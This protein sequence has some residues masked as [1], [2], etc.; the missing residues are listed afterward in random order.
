MQLYLRLLQYVKPYTKLMILSFI[1]MAVVGA[2]TAA[3]PLMIK[4]IVDNA[5]LGKQ[6]SLLLPYAL[7]LLGIG[8]VKESFRF[9]QSY[10]MRYVGE[11]V[12]MNIRNQLYAHIHTL[13]LSFFKGARTGMLMSRITNDVG[14][15]QNAVSDAVKDLFRESLTMVGLIAVAFYYDWWFALQ[16]IAIFPFFAIPF[17]IIGRKLRKISKRSQEKIADISSILQETFSGARIVKAFVRE[18]EESERFVKQNRKFFDITMKGVKYDEMSSPVMEFLGMVGGCFIILFAGY[19]ILNGMTTL[20]NV[21]TFGASVFMMY[22]PVKRLSRVYNS[23]QQGLAAAERVFE[24][25][26]TRA[27]VTDAPQAQDLPAFTDTINFEQASFSYDSAQDGLVLKDI[28]LK[29]KKGENLALVG[30]SGVGKS[31]LVD[32]IPRFYDVTQG[33]I[34][35]D[36]QDLRQIKV[37]SL[38]SHIAMVTQEIILFNDTVRGNIL[39]GRLD[40]TEEEVTAAARAAY[41][42]DF[43]MQM[44]EGYDTVIGERGVRL[45]GGERQR[46]AI[47]R[48]ILKKASIIILDEATSALDMEAEYMVQQAI[49]NLMA[50][51]TC[52]VIAHRLSTVRNAS[53]IVVLDS[54]RI[55]QIGRHDELLA[56]GGLY[57]KLY[58]MQFIMDETPAKTDV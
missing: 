14:R 17:T 5:I 46:I 36:G 45:S 38:R 4:P 21:G 12:I 44:P 49:S 27:D 51:R 15:M 13:S 52:F 50:D 34:L 32:L 53:R 39:Y 28:N 29:V 33:A 54:G 7:T 41:A 16:A 26:D 37:A 58:E 43:I 42:H 18:K 55:V 6:A 57:K 31:T 56:Q 40:A 48:A 35:I 2:A 22:Q 1:C 47:A 24:I 3:I 8:L 9:I 10:V 30:M 19:K 25:V 11:Q 20:G 23:I